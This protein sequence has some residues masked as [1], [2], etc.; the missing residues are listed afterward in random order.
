MENVVI[1]GAGAAGYTAAIYCARAN[2]EP[3]VIE[4]MQPGGQLTTTT[5][6]EN[7]PGFPEGI[8]GTKMMEKFRAQAERFGA[9]F[10][11][12]DAVAK[13]DFSQK[14]YK[15]EM[16]AGDP[17]EAKTVIIAT[18]AT[19]KYLGLESEQKFMG[20]GVSACATCDGAF[21]K[22][23]PVV[24]VGGG[25]TA[26]EEATFL[27]RFASKV[28]LV[29]RRDELRASKIM[30]ERTVKNE[31]I[32]MAWNSVIEE[33][34][35]DDSGVTGVKIRNVKTDEITEIPAS[36]YFSAIGH[37][38]NTEPFDQLEKDEVGYLIADG[39][40]TKFEGVYAAGDVSDAVYR[41]AITA[42]GTGCAAAL[43]AERYLE[44]QEG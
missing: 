18:G 4:G 8:D 31:K 33:I 39:V 20:R 34:V 38:P 7:Y 9:K 10:L 19:A 41:Q 21:Y 2:L 22:D 42:A 44:A 16:M 25:D 35:G 5:E 32:E 36:G 14:P 37:K 40:K 17:I 23:V 27:T 1:I 15:L 12:Y 3:L 26:C 6:V 11:Q 43:E 13:A 24:V 28:T 30:A 29:H